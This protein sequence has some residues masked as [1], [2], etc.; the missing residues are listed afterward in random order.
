V[1]EKVG[2]V[3]GAGNSNTAMNY[4]L[5][6]NE[7]FT[8]TQ[9]QALYYRLK[10]L[11]FDGKE[12]YSNTVLVR[13]QSDESNGLSVYPNPF[14]TDYSV[15]LTAVSEGKATIEMVDIQGKQV[16]IETR[17]LSKGVNVL[18][19]NKLESLYNGIY[20]VKVTINGETQVLKLVKN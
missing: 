15:S 6:D 16:S 13:I 3:E 1:F 17:T 8:K 18:P 14:T 12:T 4:S 7:A 2:F 11:D 19:M 10:Q 9:S 5:L 20:L